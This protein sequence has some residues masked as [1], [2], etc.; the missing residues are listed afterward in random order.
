LNTGDSLDIDW[1][2][3]VKQP[4]WD[5]ENLPAS[6]YDSKFLFAETKYNDNQTSNTSGDDPLMTENQQIL[7]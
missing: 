6:G 7:N 4:E 1:K 3:D 5:K 2:L